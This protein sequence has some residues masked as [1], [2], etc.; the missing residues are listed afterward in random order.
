MLE[1]MLNEHSSQLIQKHF[2]TQA[3]FCCLACVSYI[4]NMFVVVDM[5]KCFILLFCKDVFSIGDL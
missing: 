4:N 1:N 5:L 3:E 2:E